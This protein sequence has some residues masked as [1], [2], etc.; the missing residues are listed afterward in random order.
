MAIGKLEVVWTAGG[1]RRILSDGLFSAKKPG[2]RARIARHFC[3]WRTIAG[4]WPGGREAS[5]DE[6]T[7][8]VR[9]GSCAAC[10]SKSPRRQEEGQMTQPVS[11]PRLDRAE[12]GRLRTSETCSEDQHARTP[13]SR[14][15]ARRSGPGTLRRQHL[16][17]GTAGRIALT[18]RKDGEVSVFASLQHS[19]S[20]RGAGIEPLRAHFITG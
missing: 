16:L 1:S 4:D 18:G 19:L 17:S 14:S 9:R 8:T 11:V 6:A 10:G 3:G 20:R 7:A 13:I 5:T 15:A 12:R 2:S